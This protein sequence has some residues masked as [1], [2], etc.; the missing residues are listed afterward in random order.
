MTTGKEN[1]LSTSFFCNLQIAGHLI[2]LL[3]FQGLKTKPYDV[4]QLDSS[5][6]TF[7]FRI[8][9]S[10]ARMAP[11]LANFHFPTRYFYLIKISQV[12]ERVC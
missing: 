8:P 6:D 11:Q 1:F 12:D 2:S 4:T 10:Q 9:G 7:L 3:A 5:C